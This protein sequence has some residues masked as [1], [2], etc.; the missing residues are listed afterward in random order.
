MAVIVTDVDGL[1]QLNDTLGH[2]M[3]DA[4]LNAMGRHLLAQVRSEDT[5]ARLSGDEF[6]IVLPH[7]TRPEDAQTV[8]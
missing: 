2:A 8:V 7:L 5:V 4:A 1:K 6:G 3:G